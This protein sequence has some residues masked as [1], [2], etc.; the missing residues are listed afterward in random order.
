MQQSWEQ[1][2]GSEINIVSAEGSNHS[3]TGNFS[4]ICWH[5]GLNWEYFCT[6]ITNSSSNLYWP[7]LLLWKCIPTFCLEMRQRRNLIMI[8]KPNY[9]H[10]QFK[11]R[12]LGRTLVFHPYRLF[13]RLIPF[14][15][16]RQDKEHPEMYSEN[17]DDLEDDFSHDSLFEVQCSIYHH[18]TKLNEHHHQKCLWDLVFW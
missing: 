12:E 11:Y 1:G 10:L 13:I 14:C 3:I 17:K 18:G 5:F 7:Q 2:I 8:P 6:Y 4:F 16:S 15:H 9:K